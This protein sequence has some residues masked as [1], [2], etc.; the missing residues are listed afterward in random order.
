MH[1][2]LELELEQTN[3]DCTMF[4]SHHNNYNNNWQNY[5]YSNNQEIFLMSDYISVYADH[6]IDK[7]IVCW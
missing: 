7:Q 6:A 2:V 1:R 4:S 5:N 3:N